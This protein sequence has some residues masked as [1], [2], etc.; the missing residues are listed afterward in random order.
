[1]FRIADVER[2]T[3]ESERKSLIQTHELSVLTDIRRVLLWTLLGLSGL[4]LGMLSDFVAG[5]GFLMLLSGMLLYTILPVGG[6]DIRWLAE[7]RRN[8]DVLIVFGGMANI[9]FAIRILTS[10]TF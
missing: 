8:A 5:L 2:M 4:L 1:M 9:G 10:F 6:I 3:T 7:V